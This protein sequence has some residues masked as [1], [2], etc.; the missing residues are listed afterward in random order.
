MCPLHPQQVISWIIFGLDI[1]AYYFINGVAFSYEPAITAVLGFVYLIA[2]LMVVY[3][4]WF[5]TK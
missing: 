2:C 3:Y 4:A 5:A 1:Y